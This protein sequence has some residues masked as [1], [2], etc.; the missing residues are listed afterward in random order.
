MLLKSKLNILL[1]EDDRIEVLKLKRAI[2]EDFDNYIL[3]IATNGNQAFT[4]LDK[5]IPDIII[6]DLN[7]PDT[8]GIDFLSLIKSNNSLKHIPVIIL[9]TSDNNRD[10]FCCYKLGIA[11]YMIKPLKYEEY[12][13]K[14][15]I[16]MN[17]WSLNEFLKI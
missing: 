13:I 8:N 11:G 2:A 10:I 7:M 3:N 15:K 4:I 17:Y 12:E 1:I 16:I 14:I 9:T 5:N 6:L